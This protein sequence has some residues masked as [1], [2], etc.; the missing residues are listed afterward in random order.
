ML[1]LYLR[2]SLYVFEGRRDL[3]R[4]RGRGVGFEFVCQL[5]LYTMY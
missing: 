4:R 5:S 3:G 1:C 2:F